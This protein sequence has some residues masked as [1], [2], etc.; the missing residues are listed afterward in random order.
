MASRRSLL[1]RLVGGCLLALLVILMLPQDASA[2]CDDQTLGAVVT[3][4]DTSTAST[5]FVNAGSVAIDRTGTS[6]TKVLV[7]ASFETKNEASS[8]QAGVYRLLSSYDSQASLELSRQTSSANDYGIGSVV[9]IFDAPAEQITTFYLQHRNSTANTLNTAGTLVAIP[10]TTSAGGYSL[11]YGIVK[12]TASY[13]YSSDTYAVIP[14]TTVEM[15]LA[16]RSDVYLVSSLNNAYGS[17]GTNRTG[18]WRFLR[19][20]KTGESTWSEWYEVGSPAQRNL[21]DSSDL[22]IANLTA[23]AEAVPAGVHQF[24]VAVRVVDGGLTVDTS[25]VTLVAVA[26][27]FDADGSPASF[28]TFQATGE[29]TTTSQALVNALSHGLTLGDA[30]LVFLG[31]QYNVLTTDSGSPTGA[32]DLTL[33]SYDSTDQRR[34]ISGSSDLGSGA[35]VGLA[36][37]AA[38]SYTAALRHRS[39]DG[40]SVTLYNGI[41]VG[42]QLNSVCGVPTSVLM[43]SF[44][45]HSVPGG[46]VLR[47]Q[48]DPEF[49]GLAFQLERSM[50]PDGPFEPLALIEANS[51]GDGTYQWL[52]RDV[53]PGIHYYYRIQSIGGIVAESMPSLADTQHWSFFG[54]LPMASRRPM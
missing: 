43:G 23:I 11:T 33:G 17:G 21:A 19:R 29:H 34:F 49:G 35:S 46:I 48:A 24:A 52:D 2:G 3:A 41:L 37:V 15:T 18:E 26:L 10:L 45:A 8:K 42:I 1:T 44:A 39:L 20:T 22:G 9:N 4:I 25:N 6:A 13:S 54:H 28:P 40:K 30:G 12:R 53:S 36:S 32:Y 27:S 50:S 16:A 5:S 51:E 38:G 47:W 7:I 14:D 31:A